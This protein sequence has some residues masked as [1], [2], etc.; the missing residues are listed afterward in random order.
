LALGPAHR[1]PGRQAQSPGKPS[2]S[3]AMR[4]SPHLFDMH[5]PRKA[6]Q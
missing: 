1:H 6:C 5:A 4:S 2:L 3:G